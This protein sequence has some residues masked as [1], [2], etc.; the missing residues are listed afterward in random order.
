MEIIWLRVKNSIVARN[1]SNQLNVVHVFIENIFT[2][3]TSEDRKKCCEHRVQ[4]ENKYAKAD[5]LTDVQTE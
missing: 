2:K 4:C 5:R 1:I 3:L